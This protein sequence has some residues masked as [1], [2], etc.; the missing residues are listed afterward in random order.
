MTDSLAVADSNE[1]IS[2]EKPK[3]SKL[4][5]LTSNVIKARDIT[6]V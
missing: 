1:K 5:L 3:F 2:F 6:K 4:A